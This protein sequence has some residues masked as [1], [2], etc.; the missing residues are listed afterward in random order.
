MFSNVRIEFNESKAKYYPYPALS[1]SLLKSVAEDPHEFCERWDC[2]QKGVAYPGDGEETP[3][4]QAGRMLE[5]LL[6]RQPVHWEDRNKRPGDP[7]P[8]VEWIAKKEFTQTLAQAEALL[9]HPHA[10]YLV[11]EGC[12]TNVA[13]YAT[14][15]D[16]GLP[17]KGL[18]DSMHPGSPVQKAYVAD[19]KR[20]TASAFMSLRRWCLDMGTDIQGAT[21]L[22]L[23]EAA[24][25]EQ[26]FTLEF[27]PTHFIPVF[28]RTKY[29]YRLQAGAFVSNVNGDYPAYDNYLNGVAVL[30]ER[31]KAAAHLIK[32]GPPEP[33]LISFA[34]NRYAERYENGV[35]LAD[36]R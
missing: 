30:A 22:L 27:A 32:H 33:S 18:L 31:I 15:T 3:A 10:R 11:G 25:K 19:L 6:T 28:A 12:I 23:A 21:Y 2:L 13:I 4:Q 35:L 36:Y 24:H 1:Q 29:P 26:P 16:T 9:D 17:F 5:D 34:V 20:P 14:H 8:G 7:P